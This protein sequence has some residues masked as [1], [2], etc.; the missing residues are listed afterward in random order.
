[1]IVDRVARAMTAGAPTPGF[2]ARVMAPIE[3]R[4]RPGFTA[5]VMSALDAPVRRPMASSARL[6]FV[7]LAAV[8]IVLAGWHS[9]IQPGKLNQVQF[10]GAPAIAP[11][12]YLRAAIGMP[13]LPLNRWAPKAP[14]LP[15]RAEATAA[16]SL[17]VPQLADSVDAHYRIAAIDPPHL[18][19]LTSIE[20]VAALPAP[21]T[22]APLAAPAPLSVPALRLDKEIP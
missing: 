11:R 14:T 18:L 6:A 1:V 12:P 19:S 13:P 21:V 20:P 15:R 5:R 3:G 8:L 22:I 7:A 9:A 2:T 16:E 17:R 10:P 4:P